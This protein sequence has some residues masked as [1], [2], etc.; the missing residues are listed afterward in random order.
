LALALITPEIHEYWEQRDIIFRVLTQRAKASWNGNA[1]KISDYK[2]DLKEKLIN[3]ERPDLGSFY[4]ETEYLEGLIDK[5][6]KESAE[7][8]F[9]VLT[10]EYQKMAED[11]NENTV[12]NAIIQEQTGYEADRSY[13]SSILLNEGGNCQARQKLMASLIQRVYPNMPIQYQFVKSNNFPHTRTLIEI[14][15]D[16][17]KMELPHLTQLTENDFKATI[18]AD[19]NDYIE[20]YVGK[21]PDIKYRKLADGEVLNPERTALIVTDDY[22]N[23]PVSYDQI[24]DVSRSSVRFARENTDSASSVRFAGENTDSS[25][26]KRKSYAMNLEVLTAE[27]VERSEKWKKYYDVNTD[28]PSD[29]LGE[30]GYFSEIDIDFTWKRYLE[31]YLYYMHDKSSVVKM[32][33]SDIANFPLFQ[34]YMEDSNMFSFP[35]E[36]LSENFFII[37]SS[38]KLQEEIYKWVRP[39]LKKVVLAMDSDVR[40]EHM[41]MLEHLNIYLDT[42]NHENETEYYNLLTLDSQEDFGAENM[43]VI[44]SHEDYVRYK[45]GM[46]SDE[47]IEYFDSGQSSYNRYGEAFI[48]RRINDGF[49]VKTL[50]MWI[51]QVITDMTPLMNEPRIKF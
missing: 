41:K 25:D 12:V 19:E 20:N 49:D 6:T 14:D 10:A 13:L 47:E 4:L 3:G 11:K 23:L 21:K 16:W 35:R 44:L 46:F 7:K 26:S 40:M 18:L 37:A 50:K 43:F 48:H 45:N 28:S 33:L 34:N 31:Q 38:P 15:G 17:Y 2:E 1:N 29:M 30:E 32:S 36:Y 42:Y 22:L 8:K 24:Q 5:D 39:Y 27:E 9:N 51:N